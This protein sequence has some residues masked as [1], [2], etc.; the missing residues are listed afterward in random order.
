MACPY[1][2]VS[3]L[4]AWPHK[5]RLITNGIASFWLPW[6][7]GLTN[8]FPPSSKSTFTFTWTYLLPD[9]SDRRLTFTVCL[10][11][12]VG[13]FTIAPSR[14]SASA[15]IYVYS[16]RVTTSSTTKSC[17]VPMVLYLWVYGTVSP[18]PVPV[19]PVG[20]PISAAIKL[21]LPWWV[22]DFPGDK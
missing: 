19:S 12:L 8:I 22:H 3:A 16:T 21:S 7:H 5:Q 20:S 9:S 4:M 13:I 10:G 2:P 11:G 17:A 6:W 14:A 15:V 18:A 1:C